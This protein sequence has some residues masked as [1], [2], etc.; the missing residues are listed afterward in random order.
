MFPGAEPRTP[1]RHAGGKPRT[2]N[3]EAIL[4]QAAVY[5]VANGLPDTLEDLANKVNGRLGEDHVPDAGH[6]KTILRPLF[7]LMK[8]ELGRR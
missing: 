4:I 8:T 5:I 3:H 2:Y 7:N 6:L 1:E